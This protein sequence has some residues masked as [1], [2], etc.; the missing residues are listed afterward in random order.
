MVAYSDSNHFNLY[1][2]ICLN[3]LGLPGTW[4]AS[5][6]VKYIDIL[7]HVIVT[8]IQTLIYDVFTYHDDIDLQIS[9]FGLHNRLHWNIYHKAV[10]KFVL[11]L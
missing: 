11:R 5:F 2:N 3:Q 6:T 4:Y 9:A 1:E 10:N 7:S 8:D